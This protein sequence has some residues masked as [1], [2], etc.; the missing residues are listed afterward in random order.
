MK[1]ICEIITAVCVPAGEILA[2][3][4]L[5][6]K[7]KVKQNPELFPKQEKRGKPSNRD[8][9]SGNPGGNQGFPDFLF[10]LSDRE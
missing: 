10:W 9:R 4:A 6:L 7:V 3:F 1:N 8:T 5:S 2:R